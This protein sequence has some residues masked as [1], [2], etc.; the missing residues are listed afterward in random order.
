M[1]K[2]VIRHPGVLNIITKALVNVENEYICSNTD[3]PN[4]IRSDF[5]LEPRSNKNLPPII[6]EFHMKRAVNY[7]LQAYKRF[8]RGPIL[9]IVA[10]NPLRGDFSKCIKKC[11]DLSLYKA[12]CNYWADCCYIDDENSVL[13]YITGQSNQLKQAF[14][15]LKDDSKS[16]SDV[17]D[18]VSKFFKFGAQ[19]KRRIKELEDDDT[20]SDINANLEDNQSNGIRYQ[21]Q[22]LAN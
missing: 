16:R 15:M 1:S 22:K 17:Q 10:I 7:C 6:I 21:L 9:L 12:I 3:W 2:E 4:G 5:L 14:D 8:D 19:Q 11:A 20:V 18:F 13:N